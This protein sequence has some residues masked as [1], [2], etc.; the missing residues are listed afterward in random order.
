MIVGATQDILAIN[1]GSYLGQAGILRPGGEF[2]VLADGSADATEQQAGLQ[3]FADR[4][5]IEL[6]TFGD[7]AAANWTGL[8]AVAV[9]GGPKS[10]RQ[11]LTSHRV[12]GH[13]CHHARWLRRRRHRTRLGT[14]D[15]WSAPRPRP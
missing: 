5:G 4:N 13:R 2:G 3:W 1:I 10:T 12:R 6:R 15:C 14:G 8:A 7:T 9:L 11:V